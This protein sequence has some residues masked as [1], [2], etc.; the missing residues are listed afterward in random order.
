MVD[1]SALGELR[2]AE[3]L[4]LPQYRAAVEGTPTP[5][6]GKYTVRAPESFPA[7]AFSKTQ[8][9]FLSAAVDP[10]IIGPENEGQVIRFTRVSAAPWKDRDG[11]TVSQLG[12]Y[13]KAT[14]L[15]ETV[16]GDPQAQ[17]DAVAQTANKVYQVLIDWKGYC[18]PNKGGCGF[19]VKGMDKFPVSATTGEHVPFIPC[20]TCKDPA[21]GEPVTV[22][23]N[24]EVTRFLS[25]S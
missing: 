17:A 4:D 19:E 20:P 9:G 8:K 5:K 16:P 15:D 24:V 3:P 11:L 13:L 10:T 1:I 6:K 22:R 23:G 18:N 14:G 7:T 25:A 2:P 12:R 21:T